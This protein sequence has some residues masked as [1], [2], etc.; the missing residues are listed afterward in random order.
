MFHRQA[1]GARVWVE[2]EG[3]VYRPGLRGLR[4]LV[5]V[6]TPQ[7]EAADQSVI[8]GTFLL[9]LL[10]ARVLFDSG[11]SHSFIVASCVRVLGLEVKTLDEPLHVSS[12]L[13]TKV[14]I[15]RICWGCE[16]EIFRILLTVDLQIMDMSKFEVILGMDW[17][18][19]HRVVIDCDRM[20]VTTYT[21]DGTCVVFQGNRHDVSPH[22]VYDSRWY[23]QLTSW[24]ASLTL[25]DE[26]RRD[27]SLPQVV[28][29]YE[30][31]F[32]DELPGLPPP[33]DVD[34]H[35]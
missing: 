20:R 16:L 9:F 2:V 35:I 29:Q 25:E 5:Y 1:K 6:V 10:W 22:T 12:P 27:M 31:V 30:D 32:P 14:R 24:L 18:K 3:R 21:P 15:D 33:R 8:Q 34:F 4:G 11:A 7:T 19:A 13:G 26:V 28:C 17:L 23:G